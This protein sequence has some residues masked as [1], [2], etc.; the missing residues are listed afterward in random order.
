MFNLILFGPPGSG[1]GTQSAKLIELYN[2]VHLSTGDI[3]RSEVKAG[4]ALGV[5]AKKLMDQGNLVPD[6]V[7]IGMIE[8]NLDQHAD[9]AGF[10]FDG[11]PRTVE[12]AAALDALLER[13]GTTIHAM[14]ALDVPQSELM[15]R[16][17]ERGRIAGRV[18][19]NEHTIL[20]R[21]SEYSH[22]TKPVASFY[23]RQGKLRNIAGNS[24]IDLI[25]EDIQAQLALLPTKV[26]N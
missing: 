20:H 25:F 9:A 14:L 1:K 13:K 21:I 19:D 2:L 8:S 16:L 3:L 18:D 26:A 12:Q 24:S 4:T 22:K 17:L 7:V 10:I 23:E 11:F 5:E 15:R 6:E